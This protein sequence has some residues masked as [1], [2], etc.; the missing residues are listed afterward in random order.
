MA[1]H[2][3]AKQVCRHRKCSSGL[4][5]AHRVL[6]QCMHRCLRHRRPAR[7]SD[8]R[9]HNKSLMLVLAGKLAAGDL[10]KAKSSQDNS[11]LQP[12]MLRTQLLSAAK[13][14][15]VTGCTSTSQPASLALTLRA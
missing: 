14:L 11:K 15:T 4:Q 1:V 13:V 9:R 12:A 8:E 6:Q 3:S 2:N 10:P 7:T 5:Q